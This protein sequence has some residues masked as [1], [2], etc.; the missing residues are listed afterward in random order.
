MKVFRLYL[1]LFFIILSSAAIGQTE[2]KFSIDGFLEY[3]NNTWI[4]KSEMYNLIGMDDWQNQTSINNRFNFWWKPINNLEFNA[5]IRNIFNYGPLIA[6]YNRLF[7]YTELATFDNSFI[8]LTFP[9]AEGNSFVLY[10]N[11]DRLNIRWTLKKFVLTVGKQRINWGKNLIWNPNDIFNAYNYFDFNYVERP[12]SDAVL[13]EYYTGDF[14]SI[15]LAGKLA[16]RQVFV[17]SLAFTFKKELELTA[18]A[19]FKFNKWNYDFQVFAGTMQTD[20]TAGVGWAGQ[21]AGAGF[22]GEV[23]WFRDA[24]NFPDT[25]GVYVASTGLNYTFKNSLFLQFSGIYNSAGKKGPANESIAG[26]IGYFASVFSRNLNAKNL[27]PS[28]FSIFGQISYPAT[29]LIHLDLASI[30]N[31]SDKSVFVGPSA[32]FSLTENISLMTVGQLFWG[33]PFTE[34]G[35]IGQM[36]FLDLKWSF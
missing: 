3:T 26:V 28:R 10:T 8:D 14:S 11:I 36:Y 35:D 6:N 31:P 20:I 33:N 2:K 24:E 27:T 22:T 7:D 12:G 15:Q 1:I 23:S 9:I 34:F 16:Y 19:M 32:T 30:Y 25:S 29:P 21:I 4:P 5:G 17:D 13:A 18:A